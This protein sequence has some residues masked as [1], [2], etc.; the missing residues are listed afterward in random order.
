[1]SHDAYA[2]VSR[3]SAAPRDA[4]YQAF[5]EATRRLMAADE[6]DPLDLRPLI[7]A[8]HLNRSLWGALAAD[9]SRADNKL[10]AQTRAQIIGLARWVGAYSS[11]AM[12]RRG[13]L[14]PLIDVNRIIMDGLSGRAAQA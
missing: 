12:R 8:V 3:A 14:Q 9:C 7:E 4:E 10:P 5:S 1:M 6:G 11:D 13:S 2:R